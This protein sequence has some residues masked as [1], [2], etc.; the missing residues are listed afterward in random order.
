MMMTLYDE[1]QI[2]KNQEYYVID[3]HT[4]SGLLVEKFNQLDKSQRDRI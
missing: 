4:D 2:R 3:I 1:D